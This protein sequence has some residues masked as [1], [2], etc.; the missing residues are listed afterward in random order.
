MYVELMRARLDLNK[1]GICGVPQFQGS[2]LK[3][4]I[5][6]TGCNGDFYTYY[7]FD[8]TQVIKNKLV[9]SFVNKIEKYLEKNKDLKSILNFKKYKNIAEPSEMDYIQ[10]CYD[11]FIAWKEG[12][13]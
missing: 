1:I 3:M 13:R 2:R 11:K 12:N 9:N 7:L 10:E 8:D 5:N 4:Y 6:T